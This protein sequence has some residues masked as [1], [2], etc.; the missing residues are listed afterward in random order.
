MA[1]IPKVQRI[2][3]PWYQLEDFERVKTVMVDKHLLS[4]VYSLWRQKAEQMERQLRRQGQ[5]VIR[6]P[7]RADEFVAWCAA[8][9]LN[10]DANGRREY[11]AWFA[12]Q[13]DAQR[14]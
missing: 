11:A 12:A 1:T 13:P 5:T 14:H 4:P 2:G 9:G 10:V 3:I 7:L 8:R 6:A